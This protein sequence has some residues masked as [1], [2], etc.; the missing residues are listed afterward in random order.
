M[1]GR[2]PRGW[3]R[4]EQATEPAS[5][6]GRPGQLCAAALPTPVLPAPGH[7]AGELLSSLQRCAG[8]MGAAPL[9]PLLGPVSLHLPHRPPL[10]SP[11]AFPPPCPPFW[12][13]HTS[14]LELSPCPPSSLPS[15]SC[16]WPAQ[17]ISPSRFLLEYPQSYPVPNHTLFISVQFSSV[18]QLCP[19]L[20]NP[21][22][23]S[24]PGLPVHHQLPEFTQTHVH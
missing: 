16:P 7:G 24:I 20:C 4:G 22:N 23:R 6:T 14:G 21:M 9:F 12:P 13:A 19:T 10:S 17:P 18:A 5:P 11:P 3:G 2:W 1:A 8:L 15:C